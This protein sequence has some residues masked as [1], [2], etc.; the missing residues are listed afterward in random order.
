[1]NQIG[2]ERDASRSNEDDRLYERRDRQSD[3]ADR[4]G[5]NSVARTDD[6][7]VSESVRVTVCSV[8]MMTVVL[9]SVAK[10]M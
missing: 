4:D 3:E 5:T 9:V 7:P 10:R 6:R 2:K 8:P 1:M